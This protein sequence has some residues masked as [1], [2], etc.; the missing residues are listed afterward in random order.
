MLFIPKTC[1]FNALNTQGAV[2]APFGAFQS[3]PCKI[4]L[5]ISSPIQ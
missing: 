4:Y 3:Y 5:N 2:I 1:V